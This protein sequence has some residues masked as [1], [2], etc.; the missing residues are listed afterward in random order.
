MKNLENVFSKFD[1]F[2]NGRSLTAENLN[3]DPRR[4]EEIDEHADLLRSKRAPLK[5]K[6]SE[7]RKERRSAAKTLQAK[8][9]S[10]SASQEQIQEIRADIEQVV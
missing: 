3:A 10:Q 2:C 5:S 4:L 9:I 1:Q 8:V 6:L 7:L